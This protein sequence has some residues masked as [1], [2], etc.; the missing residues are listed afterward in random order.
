MSDDLIEGDAIAAAMRAVELLSDRTDGLGAEEVADILRADIVLWG[1]QKLTR[2][3]LMLIGIGF[4]L[5]E[6]EP[7]HPELRYRMISACVMRLHRNP[8]E[9]IPEVALPTVAGAL[10]AAV[11]G[12]DVWAWRASLG[13]VPDNELLMWAHVAWTMT[14]LLDD[15]LG[16]AGTFA[17][18]V[19]KVINADD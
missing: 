17:Q 5:I 14:E 10:T 6:V 11:L 16:G 9:E 4:G 8:A 15:Y 12:H 13:T 3:L 1:H 2:S 7:N 19:E 18:L